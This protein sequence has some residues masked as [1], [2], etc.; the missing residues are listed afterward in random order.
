MLAGDD[1]RV[2]KPTRFSGGI[3]SIRSPW[4]A[5]LAKNLR[6]LLLLIRAG[7]DHAGFDKDLAR[8]PNAAIS[9]SPAGIR[10]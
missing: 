3:A 8:R 10:S 9:N 5:G 4:P 2:T 1:D 6:E 7:V